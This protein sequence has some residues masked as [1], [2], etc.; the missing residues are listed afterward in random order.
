VTVKKKSPSVLMIVNLYSPDHSRDN[1]YLSNYATIQLRDELSRLSGVGDISFLGQR[2]YSMRVWLD[3]ERLAMRNLDAADVVRAIE[4]QNT[5]V[6]AGQI[7]QPPAP[8]GQA[9]QYTMTT[10][11]RL[12]DTEQFGDMIL[13]TD[14][15]GRVTRLHDVARTELGA[16]AYDQVCTLDGQP[17]VALSIY[18]LPGTNALQTARQ[19]R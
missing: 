19:V 17:S 5:Q 12:A 9:F 1:L 13:R 8:T 2:D 10:L 16:L 6:A 14:G 4:Q 7:G 3:P 15:Q 18:Q 11:G